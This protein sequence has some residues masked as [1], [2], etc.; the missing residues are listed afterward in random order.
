MSKFFLIMIW[1]LLVAV[2]CFRNLPRMSH[3]TRTSIVKITILVKLNP[4]TEQFFSSASYR[5]SALLESF[6]SKSQRWFAFRKPVWKV[7]R[8]QSSTFYFISSFQICRFYFKRQALNSRVSVVKL[9]LNKKPFQNYEFWTLNLKTRNVFW[10][11]TLNLS[12]PLKLGTSKSKRFCSA[13]RAGAYRC[14]NN[15]SNQISEMDHGRITWKK[16]LA[17]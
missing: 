1:Y 4:F 13:G 12:V 15:E 7:I 17:P 2:N 10:R 8:K 16:I 5:K 3:C 6:L 9:K 14:I 11:I